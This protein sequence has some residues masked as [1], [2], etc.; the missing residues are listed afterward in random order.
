M[1]SNLPSLREIVEKYGI[2]ARKQLGQNFI[3]DLNLTDK[4]AR[5]AGNLTGKT[6]LEIGP[7]PGGLTR[8]ILSLNPEKLIA[9]EMDK[10]CLEALEILKNAYSDKIILIEGDALR[11][12]ENEIKQKYSSQNKIKIIANLPYNIATELL[13]KWL[14]KLELFE[15]FTLMFQKEV[16]ERIAAKPGN[17]AYGRV[18]VMAQWL[19]DSRKE[20]DV[21]P[22]AFF[23]PPK[24]T[25]SIV[26]LI[27]REKPLYPADKTTL[28]KILKAVFG[29]R[30]KMLRGS[31][32]RLI[33]NP[34]EILKQAGIDETKRPEDL[35]IKDFCALA[36][37]LNKWN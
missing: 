19:C 26:T 28:E 3:F 18:S 14:D 34:E 12:D 29:Q 35:E 4:I 25:S 10:K 32:K 15:S 20:F 16:A 37:I 13:F 36:S 6:I 1:H 27:P 21:S 33:K 11:I 5:T 9:A 22:S 31:M 7:G 2:N 17:K 30:R 24:V 8:S 23:P